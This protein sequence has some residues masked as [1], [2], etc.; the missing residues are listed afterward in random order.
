MASLYTAVCALVRATNKIRF[1]SEQSCARCR[2]VRHKTVIAHVIP[3]QVA[4]EIA[5]EPTNLEV[6]CPACYKVKIA[7]DRRNYR[8]LS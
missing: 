3:R 1:G 7:E 4:P 8:G 6:L 5:Y 2:R